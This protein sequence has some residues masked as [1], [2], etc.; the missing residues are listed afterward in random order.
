MLFDL[1]GRGRRRTVR[2]LYIGL[3]VL[4]G[5]GL[6]GFGVGT[7][8][9]GGGI[10]SAATGIEAD[11]AG[12]RENGDRGEAGL[13][14]GHRALRPRAECTD[15]SVSRELPCEAGAVRNQLYGDSVQRATAD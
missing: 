2:I 1:R 15:A 14:H 4:I 10:F 11:G 12:Q 5:L 6:V 3:A 13:P 7:G 9:G 8:F